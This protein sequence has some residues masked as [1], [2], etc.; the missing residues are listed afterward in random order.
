MKTSSKMTTKHILT[1]DTSVKVEVVRS[2]YGFDCPVVTVTGGDEFGRYEIVLGLA[3][4]VYG[5]ASEGKIDLSKWGVNINNCRL[6]LEPCDGADTK[7][8]LA[9]L[10]GL[11]YAQTVRSW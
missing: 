10:K 5:L 1:S 7:Q 4:Q 2:E 3:S 6:E 8:G 9:I 11:D